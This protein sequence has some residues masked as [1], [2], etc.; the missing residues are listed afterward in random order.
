MPIVLSAFV[1][2]LLSPDVTPSL[3]AADGEV[4]DCPRVFGSPAYKRKLTK[5]RKRLLDDVDPNG[6]IVDIAH[7]TDWRRPFYLEFTGVE[8]L[9]AEGD[10][11][12]A[13]RV[14]DALA[15]L[16]CE[17]GVYHLDVDDSLGD[18][19]AI[20]AVL[21]DVVLVEFKGQLGYLATDDAEIPTWRMIWLAPWRI[22]RRR[23]TGVS[24]S[25]MPSRSRSR[26]RNNRS[27]RRR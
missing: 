10:E 8:L 20:L 24:R 23:E 2:A 21:D 13:F 15:D 7:S 19:T 3:P 18:D 9:A 11:G 6:D 14:D 12:A 22:I 17:P 4:T 26:A 16:D 5:R 25:T 1:L 27:R